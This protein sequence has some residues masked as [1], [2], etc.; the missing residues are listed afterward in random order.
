MQPLIITLRRVLAAAGQRLQAFTGQLARGSQ[1]ER[2]GLPRPFMVFLLLF[3]AGMILIS[4]IGDQG[5][6]AY[7]R[8]QNEVT[9]LREV[10][11]ALE[12]S[13]EE[14]EH[15]IQALRDNPDYIELQARKNLGLVR[16]GDRIYQLPLPNR[17]P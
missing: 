14:L 13:Q 6:F 2:E 9:H 15:R 11:A 10:V 16:P 17:H 7:L 4:L 8:M 3:G 1:S 5:L 12:E